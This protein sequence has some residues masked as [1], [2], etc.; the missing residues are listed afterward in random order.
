MCVRVYV[1]VC[2]RVHACVCVCVCVCI[3]DVCM[4]GVYVCAC[5]VCMCAWMCASTCVHACVVRVCVFTCVRVCMRVHLPVCRCA[6][7]STLCFSGLGASQVLIILL[8]I[9]SAISLFFYLAA[10]RQRS[11]ERLFTPLMSREASI[12][13]RIQGH[14]QTLQQQQQQQQQQQ[15]LHTSDFAD[16][17]AESTIPHTDEEAKSSKGTSQ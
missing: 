3:Y 14:S 2:V 8:G 1:C 9:C 11:D 12:A 17:R 4:P 7:L 13:V 6:C 5:L 16:K 15:P 10:R